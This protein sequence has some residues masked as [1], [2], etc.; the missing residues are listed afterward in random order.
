MPERVEIGYGKTECK[1]WCYC[2]WSSTGCFWFSYYCTSC[3]WNEVTLLITDICICA[4]CSIIYIYLHTL[5]WIF[6]SYGLFIP[7][8]YLYQI[9]RIY[10]HVHCRVTR[11]PVFCCV[12]LSWQIMNGMPNVLFFCTINNLISFLHFIFC[13]YL[14]FVILISF[15][16]TTYWGQDGSRTRLGW[17]WCYA[18]YSI[19]LAASGACWRFLVEL[20]K[21]N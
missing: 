7:E 12:L 18:S 10:L 15:I 9:I 16:Y 4:W 11:H 2:S 13:F 6:C 5:L 20:N 1:W 21:W 3:P 14:F 8:K 17:E 19:L